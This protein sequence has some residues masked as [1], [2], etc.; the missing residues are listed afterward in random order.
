M[1]QR[2]LLIRLSLACLFAT[3]ST[4]WFVSRFYEQTK[5]GSKRF[6]NENSIILTIHRTVEMLAEDSVNKLVGGCA[7]TE[8]VEF[9]HR[10]GKLEKE[11]EELRRHLEQ[12]R[13]G[14]MDV[15]KQL[16]CERKQLECERKG[17]EEAEQE[18]RQL[19]IRL[20]LISAPIEEPATEAS[21]AAAASVLEQSSQRI[22]DCQTDNT[23]KPTGSKA[24]KEDYVAA[25]SFDGNPSCQ[26]S[27]ERNYLPSPT[28][29]KESTIAKVEMTDS[30]IYEP[31]VEAFNDNRSDQA[32]E[33]SS[34][35]E[36]EST[37]SQIQIEGDEQ[38]VKRKSEEMNLYHQPTSKRI[39]REI[40]TEDE[41]EDYEVIAAATVTVSTAV[42][43]TVATAEIESRVKKD[44]E[45]ESIQNEPL[46]SPQYLFEPVV[47]IKQEP[48]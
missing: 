13:T 41:N 7:K 44:P 21:I 22:E 40:N 26:I 27:E 48:S 6:L 4:S 14:K 28:L 19:R 5:K 10:A 43:I 23:L 46:T 9:K 38:E 12:E 37:V 24:A 15:Q 8:L 36:K 3:S 42:A 47:K 31:V 35:G 30:A 34:I 2:P 45:T 18:L 1:R 20:R 16:E 17:R 29:E 33:E 39:K 32:T 11:N 25:T